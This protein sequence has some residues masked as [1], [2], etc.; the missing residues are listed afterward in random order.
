M[1]HA[2]LSRSYRIATRNETP[3][4]GLLRTFLNAGFRCLHCKVGAYHGCTL[5]LLDVHA[6]VVKGKFYRL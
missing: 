6:N 3:V 5:Y 2:A 1:Q 4:N